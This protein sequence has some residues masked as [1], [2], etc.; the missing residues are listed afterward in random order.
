MEDTF[1]IPVSFDEFVIWLNGHTRRTNVL[2]AQVMLWESSTSATVTAH[3]AQHVFTVQEEADDR[4]ALHAEL[5]PG[6]AEPT[7]EAKK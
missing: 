7:Q 6:S 3:G 4:T 1:T 2:P 5:W